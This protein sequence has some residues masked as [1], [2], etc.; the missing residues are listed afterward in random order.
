VARVKFS[1]GKQREFLDQI[2]KESLLSWEKLG[3]ICRV[4]GRTLRDWKREKY[5][6]SYE[7]L[8]LL[9]KK[10][11]IELPKGFN[12]LDDFWYVLKGARKGAL[13]RN[14]LYGL[15]GTRESRRKGGII[16]QL[17]RRENPEYYRDLGCVVRNKFKKPRHSAKLAEFIGILL[18]DG[19]IGNTQTTVFLNRKDDR[20]YA[21]FVCKLINNL[22]NYKPTSSD[23]QY[24]NTLTIRING[25]DFIN[26]LENLGLKRGNKIKNNV[27]VPRWIE[28]NNTFSLACVRG[29]FDTDGGLYTHKH[30]TNGI[31]Y[32]NLGWNFTSYSPALIKFMRGVLKEGGFNI[33]KPKEGR[34]YIYGLREIRRYFKII[35]THN[36]KHFLKLKQHL[37]KP[38]RIS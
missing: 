2:H 25:V 20:D 17:R 16:S 24:K 15:P 31:K 21:K 37:A 38:Q 18:G 22:F 8:L 36:P 28:E 10:F 32:R 6:A 29:L 26:L 27:N 35:G 23:Y 4:S 30:W 34:L 12:V 19:N 14:E 3:L 33:K 9:S 1:F 7:A 13:R 5:T 11:N